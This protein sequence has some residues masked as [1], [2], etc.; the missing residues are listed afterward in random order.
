MTL[1][2]V[3]NL[4]FGSVLLIA[5]ALPGVADEE[6]PYD[7]RKKCSNC[8]KSQHDSW[9]LTGHAKAL[10]SLKPGNKSEAKIKAKL[11]P[12]KDYSEDK[13]CVGCHVTGFGHEGGYDIEDPSKYLIGV[14][15]E[16][17][18]GPGSEY[19][20]VHRKAGEKFER[21]NKTSPRQVL[22]DAG[23][24]FHFVERCNACHLNYEGSPWP[25]AKAPYTPF[26]PD[27]DPKYAFDFD[28]AVRDD[29]AMHAHFKLEGTFTGEPLP[30]FHEEF[31]AT[32]KPINEE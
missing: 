20:L 30:P 18:H 29:K 4:L 28:K 9:K 24:E 12:D 7:G 16:S 6:P 8:H 11:D 15:C 14:T 5:V 31:Q 23:E 21:K 27:V 3:L 1:R 10:L 25:G 2:A 17:C 26:T 22:V 13:K 32:A 19:R